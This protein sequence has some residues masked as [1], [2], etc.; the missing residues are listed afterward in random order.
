MPIDDNTVLLPIDWAS[1]IDQSKSIEGLILSHRFTKKIEDEYQGGNRLKWCSSWHDDVFLDLHL[2]KRLSQHSWGWLFGTPSRALWRHCNE[3]PTGIIWEALNL[4]KPLKYML[5]RYDIYDRK[6]HSCC[7][8]TFFIC[9]HICWNGVSHVKSKNKQA[10][11]C[12]TLL[13]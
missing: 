3:L 1:Q 8:M 4:T 13:E 10:T 5:R 11:I 7:G 12:Q 2:N 6:A 9:I